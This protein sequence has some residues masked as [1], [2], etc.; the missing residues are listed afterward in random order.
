MSTIIVTDSACDLPDAFVEQ[1][2]IKKLPL[3]IYL[4]GETFP[5]KTTEAERLAIYQKGSLSREHDAS[6]QPSS[7]DDVYHYFLDKIAV[8]HD[9][10]IGQT[11]S[12]AR[13]PNFENWQSAAGLVQR[14]Y[15]KLRAA[16]G[17]TGSFG[18]RIINSGT[19]FTG[20]GILAAHS[21]KLIHDGIGRNQLRREIE[22][23][24]FKIRTLAVPRDV[25]YLRERARKKGDKSIGFLASLVGKTMDISPILRG[26]QDVTEPVVKVR[27]REAAVNRMFTYAMHRMNEGLCTPYIVVSIAGDPLALEQFEKFREMKILAKAKDIRVMTTVMNLSGG[28]NM[29]PDTVSISLASDNEVLDV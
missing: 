3:N 1:N 20:Q 19:M 28:I 27:G 22:D 13:S 10:A 11:V 4:N 26:Y 8:Q 15:H 9:F 24:K 5:D 12:K 29:G 17:R 6:S 21:C 2:P 7:V 18:I 14:D 16:G 25:A 23:F